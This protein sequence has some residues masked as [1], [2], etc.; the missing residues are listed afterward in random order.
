ML[1]V[2]VDWLV[3]PHTGAI[4]SYTVSDVSCTDSA[5]SEG[6]LGEGTLFLHFR[7]L[8]PSFTEH[9]ER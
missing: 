8:C 4:G 2:Q 6:P 9:S 7:G 5:P 1:C 3:E